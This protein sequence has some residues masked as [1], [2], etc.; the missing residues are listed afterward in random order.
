MNYATGSLWSHEHRP[1][2]LMA[3]FNNYSTL[4]MRMPAMKAPH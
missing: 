1:T 2:L 3:A 4:M